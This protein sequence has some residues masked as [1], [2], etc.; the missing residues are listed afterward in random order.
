[1]SLQSTYDNYEKVN[2]VT[3]I[4]GYNE[5][6]TPSN[7]A[8]PN[9]FDD[10]FHGDFRTARPQSLSS[11]LGK[12]YPDEYN[13]KSFPNWRINS[14]IEV[15]FDSPNGRSIANND[16]AV[17]FGKSK[18]AKITLEGEKFNPFRDVPGLNFDG[19]ENALTSNVK[20]PFTAKKKISIPDSDG[21]SVDGIR[22]SS[23]YGGSDRYLTT[24][25]KRGYTLKE[26]FALTPGGA[27]IA[28]LAD[29]AFMIHV[30]TFYTFTDIIYM[31]DG[32]KVVRL[33]D[34]SK[35]P[36]HDLYVDETREDGN[37][38]REGIEWV[39]RNGKHAAFE[40]FAFEGNTVGLTPFDRSGSFLYRQKMF[41]GKGSHPV[42]TF[43][44]NGTIFRASTV[45]NAKSQ[46][47]FP[48]GI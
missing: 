24:A 18:Q 4:L 27:I 1:M 48:S 21:N 13:G 3:S 22:A 15:G 37:P 30:T 36:A 39:R 25:K 41:K 8:I 12:K 11:A 10:W 38:F 2:S 19:S 46:P 42:G 9:V 33:W 28:P 40:D 23:I 26:L 34:A 17:S 29:S 32:A 35:Y 44:D 7:S 16:W 20:G 45:A 14:A 47:L 31:A 5:N 43:T 6:G